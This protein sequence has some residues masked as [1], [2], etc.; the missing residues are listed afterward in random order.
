M[1]ECGIVPTFMSLGG[2]LAP[3]IA[4]DDRSLA[5]LI[6]L[7]GASR[8][9]VE[10]AREQLVY[11][12]SLTPGA[13]DPDEALARLRRMA[14]EAYWNDL[15]AYRPAHMAATLVMPMPILQGER[16]YQVTL[17][18]LQGWRDALAGH[19]A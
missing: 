1:H 7:A 17:E 4:A 16:D 13:I 8:P 10:A 3:R 19:P 12:A 9:F 18:D 15:D 5:G 2:T 6:I 14:P 11:L